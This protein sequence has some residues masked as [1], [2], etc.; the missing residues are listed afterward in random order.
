MM[1]VQKQAVMREPA[2]LGLNCTLI[3]VSLSLVVAIIRFLVLAVALPCNMCVPL[4][5]CACHM[6]PTR[7]ALPEAKPQ[8][9]KRL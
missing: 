6:L 8:T 1:E 4:V 5:C 3:L 9:T 2:I 7:D